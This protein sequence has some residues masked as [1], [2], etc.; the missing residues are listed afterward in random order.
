MIFMRYHCIGKD[1]LVY[2]NIGLTKEIV[3]RIIELNPTG[4]SVIKSNTQILINEESFL[5]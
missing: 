3:F 1:A 5:L 2:I 4:I